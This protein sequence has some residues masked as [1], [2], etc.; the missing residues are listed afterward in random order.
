MESFRLYG[1]PPTL[2]K[3]EQLNLVF[4]ELRLS[5]REPRCMQCGGELRAADKESLRDRIPTQ[6]VSLA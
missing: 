2:T 3:L 6:D 5:V 4:R 1:V